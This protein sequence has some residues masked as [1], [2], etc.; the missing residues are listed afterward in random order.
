VFE[1]LITD[2]GYAAIALGAFVEG[3]T[4]LLAAGALAQR[5]LVSLPLV[6]LCGIAGSVGWSQLWF[7]LGRRFG[8]AALERRPAWQAR[9]DDMQRW[10][11]RYEH[12]FVLGFRFISG[13][14]TAAP[15]LLGASGYHRRRF[16][17]LDTLGAG[18]WAAAF[19]STGYGIGVGLRRLLGRGGG[20][21][22]LVAVVVTVAATVGLGLRFALNR[23]RY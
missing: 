9:S 21:L 15:V 3:E 6:V 22:E 7:H 20:L 14:G 10:L 18:L 8:R 19:G 12:L 23:R 17:A 13:V 1:S 16:T 5:G 4:V 2:W 11:T